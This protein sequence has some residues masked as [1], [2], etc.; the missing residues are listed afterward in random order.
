MPG[1]TANGFSKLGAYGSVNG[2]Y[3]WLLN[4]NGD[5]ATATSVV[6]ALQINGLPFAYHFNPN[7][8]GDQIGLF[9]GQG[10]WYIDFAGTN[11]MGPGTIT[12]HDGLTG[13]PIVGDFD[14]NGQ[15]DLA[16]YRP[17][18]KTFTLT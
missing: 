17:D 3:R 5:G 2:V 16:T 4:F 7:L 13:F 9:D 1:Q 18:Q 11:D 8:S 6:S 12:I 15:F 14:G 10:N